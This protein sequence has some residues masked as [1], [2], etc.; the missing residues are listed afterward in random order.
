MKLRFI[1]PLLIGLFGFLGTRGALAGDD[2]AVQP[3]PAPLPVSAAVPLWTVDLQ[4]DYTLGSRFRWYNGLGSQAEYH[5]RLDAVRRINFADG[6]YFR[7]GPDLERFDFSRSNAALPYSLNQV[8][9]DVG[10]EYWS[11]GRLG[12]QLRLEPGAY[13]TRD[14]VTDNSFDIPVTVGVGYPLR[15]S[16]DLVVGLRASILDEYPVLPGGGL[17]W[18]ATD[19]L[20]VEAV[21]PRPNISYKLSDSTQVFAGGELLGGAFRNGPTND[22][23]T[24]NAVLEYREYRAGAGVSFNP[25]R[26]VSASL[27]AGWSFEREFDYFHSGPSFRTKG[28]PYV[29]L[30]LRLEL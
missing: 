24:N 1:A 7:V 9:A 13:F 20:K 10:V 4:G 16:L 5:Y 29:E 25:I 30:N 18:R 17:I 15:P 19:R 23:R 3:P 27:H 21:F 11:K 12:F 8:A 2:K 26:S 6:W 14:H 28:A 22:R